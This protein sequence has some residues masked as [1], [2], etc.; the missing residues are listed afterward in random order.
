MAVLFALLDC[1]PFMIS[2]TFD[3]GCSSVPCQLEEAID[4]GW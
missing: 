3:A 2:W 1:E 4:S